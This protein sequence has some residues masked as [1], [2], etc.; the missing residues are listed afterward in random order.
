MDQNELKRSAARAALAEL[1]DGGIIGIGTGST[2]NYFIEAL[3][4]VRNRVEAAVSSSEASTQRLTA[5]GIPIADLNDVTSLTVYVDGADE[6]TPELAMIKGGGGALTREKIVAAVAE[7]FIC[8]V[9]GS[10]LVQRL[11]RFPLPIEVIP[12]AQA[13]V[14]RELRK[15]GGQPQLRAGFTTDNGNL[16]LDVHELDIAQ[17]QELES[18]LNQIVG[19]V[20]NGLFARR[21]ANIALIAEA[22]GVRRLVG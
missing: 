17:P 7:R 3:A 12:C 22:G 15:L 11:G 20:C 4:D 16:I 2:V 10:K 1:G 8:I 9:D 14:A 18:S 5:L 21:G 6:I 19:V 13:H